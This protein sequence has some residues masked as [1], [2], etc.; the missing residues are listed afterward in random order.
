ML[1]ED[2]MMKTNYYMHE[3][4][5]KYYTRWINGPTLMEHVL[6]RERFYR[7]VKACIRYSRH[8]KAREDI[9]GSWLRYF[10]ERDLSRRYSEQYLDEIIHEIVVLFEHILEFNKTS[11]PDYVLEMRNPYLVSM[12]LRSYRRIDVLI[13]MA[14]RYHITQMTK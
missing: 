11:F 4:I 3:L 9:H 10:L 5:K 2:F 13:K 12:E 14:N 1:M 8:W 6:D 7:F